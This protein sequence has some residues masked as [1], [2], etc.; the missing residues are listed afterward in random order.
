MANA[1][2]N[3]LFLAYIHKP[4]EIDSSSVLTP[5]LTAEWAL[6]ALIDFT[7]SNSRR[8]YS[9]MGNPLDGKGLKRW[10]AFAHRRIALAFSK[11]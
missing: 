5:Q 11:E 1:R 4:T 9:S 2:L 6:R 3:G 10:D 8:L 7:L